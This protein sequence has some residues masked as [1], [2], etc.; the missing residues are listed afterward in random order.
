MNIKTIFD[1]KNVFIRSN[2]KLG[3]VLVNGVDF[4]NPES[5]EKWREFVTGLYNK[6][7]LDDLE[8]EGHDLP[9]KEKRRKKKE[10]K[11][12]KEQEKRKKQAQRAAKKA[13]QEEELKERKSKIKT[14]LPV[15]DN[16]IEKPKRRGRPL[17]DKNKEQIRTK[18]KTLL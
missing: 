17:K 9:L 4:H 14:L 8:E 1:T 7:Y 15:D 2:I 11:K 13:R 5:K 12:E 3:C 6:Y 18:Q 10:K 16:P